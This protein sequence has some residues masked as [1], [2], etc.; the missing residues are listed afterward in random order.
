MQTWKNNTDIYVKKH[1]LWK[2]QTIA[3]PLTPYLEN[4]VKYIINF[5]HI[6]ISVQHHFDTSRR[7][8]VIKLVLARTKIQELVFTENKI[9]QVKE[10]LDT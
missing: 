6:H 4:G 3:I 2:T 9:F 10:N 8:H 1:F 7:F 5:S